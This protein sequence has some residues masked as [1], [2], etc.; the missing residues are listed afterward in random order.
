MER[1][2]EMVGE[3]PGLTKVEYF[4]IDYSLA[5]RQ[6]SS[7]RELPMVRRCLF[8]RLECGSNTLMKSFSFRQ[9]KLGRHA[10]VFFIENEPLDSSSETKR[11][12]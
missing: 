10:I 2:L 4:E 7:Y 11:R 5:K 6:G 12:R 8:Y 1:F 3:R 9:P